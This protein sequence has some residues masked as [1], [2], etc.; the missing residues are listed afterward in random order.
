MF[1]KEKQK[2]KENTALCC[3]KPHKLG[4]FSY[5]LR[6][7]NFSTAIE[8]NPKSPK[9]H[10]QHLLL[11]QKN[12]G[13]VSHLLLLTCSVHYA[14]G[15]APR[16]NIGRWWYSL[17]RGDAVG[18]DTFIVAD[19]LLLGDADLPAQLIRDDARVYRRLAQQRRLKG[20]RQHTKT[21]RGWG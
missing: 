11:P 9:T 19:A 5:N 21:L 14:P 8:T 10:T 6:Q 15:I 20:R 12:I 1:W 3:I 13:V 4:M 7:H 18:N 17:M 2:E 16:A